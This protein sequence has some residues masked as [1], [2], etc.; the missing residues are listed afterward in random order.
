[1]S[2][3]IVLGAYGCSTPATRTASV[4]E[5]T[6][7]PPVAV[8]EVP[9]DEQEENILYPA[10]EELL[11]R[12]LNYYDDAVVAHDQLDFGL[13]ETKVDSALV[14]IRQIDIDQVEDEG[15]VS[16]FKS[17][18]FSLGRERGLIIS[19][20]EEIAQQDYTS[21]LD[22]LDNI[23]NFKSGRWTDE[24]L[25]KIVMRVALKSDVPIEYNE[26]VKKAI[27]FFQTN[28]R[29]E[30]VKWL[31][32]SGKYISLMQEIFDEEG[33]PHDLVYLSM[34]ESGFNP[35]AYSRAHAV[36]LWQF[37][38]STGKLYG[39]KRNEWIDERKD[40][41]KAT[42]AAARHLKDLYEMYGDWNLVFAAYNCGPA[43]INRLFRANPNI[44]YWDINLPRETQGY[45]PFFMAAV[46]ISKEPEIFGFENIEPDDPMEYDV[47][48]AH[49][50]TPLKVIAQS[51]GC[52]EADIKDL[53]A[54]IL[55]DRTPVGKE[56]YEV[57]IP[58]DTRNAFL[59]AYASYSPEKY[60]PPRVS[61]YRVRR[62]DT[63]STIARRFGVSVSSLMR[64]N[65][66]RNPRKLR[67]GQRLNIPGTVATA[68]TSGSSGST[69]AVTP[70]V[71]RDDAVK[72]KVQRN[73][74][75]GIIAERFHTNVATIQ[76]LN[77]M[78]RST[79]IYLG[80]SIL[81][82]KQNSQ[83]GESASNQTAESTSKPVASG[84]SLSATQ[85]DHVIYVIKKGDSLYE[86]AQNYG[87]SYK[88]IMVWNKIRN[89][90][91]I[92]PGQEIIIKTKG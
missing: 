89:H 4:D 64:A 47:V 85:S 90:R 91:Q 67:I 12:I 62:G 27:Y 35:K 54:E 55:R 41:V 74:T 52:T 29:K 65:N 70:V 3:T 75:L 6:I 21:W 81:V 25:R 2:L 19:E 33:L 48:E 66:I 76:T 73:D 32:R 28:R 58:K 24:D 18:V 87:V 38:Y 13:A 17:A 37:I 43:R 72:Y 56:T 22:E 88:D 86:I 39:L 71:S 7:L 57:R 59:T 8:V 1:M 78:G 5:Q 9:D 61:T 31:G 40:P 63:P 79:R 69:V 44:S 50:Y 10:E 36:G 68:S 46:I 23:E 26:R 30:M 84:N 60:Q 92:K 53:N 16:R 80:Q 82:P 45:V 51:A 49:P 34:I 20:S 14:L 83:V 77:K 15:L 11:Q 42:R